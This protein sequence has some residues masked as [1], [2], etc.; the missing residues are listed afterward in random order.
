MT[1]AQE[2]VYRAIAELE[3]KL[4]YAP[5]VR[6]VAERAGLASTSTTHAHLMHLLAAGHIRRASRTVGYTAV[7]EP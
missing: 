3:R 2:R 1:P 5:T 7:R 4:G 6:Q